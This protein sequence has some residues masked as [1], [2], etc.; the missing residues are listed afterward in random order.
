M[1]DPTPLP[2]QVSRLASPLLV[3]VLMACLAWGLADVAQRLSPTWPAAYFVGAAFV[4]ALVGYYSYHAA[5]R[6][7][8]SGITLWRYYLIE[9]VVMFLLI[10]LLAYAAGGLGRF[11]ADAARWTTQP[12]TFFDFETVAIW[13]MAVFAWAEGRAT[14]RDMDAICDP[15]LYAGEKPPLER[16]IARF[17]GGAAL[18]LAATGIARA[19]LAAALHQ[20]HPR[21][22]GLMLNVLIY[23]IV[24]LA[25]MGQL[26]FIGLEAGWRAQRYTILADLR[27]R[28]IQY[29]LLLL[30]AALL[31]AF[32]LPTGY[33]VGLLDIAAYVVA[34]IA[35][36]F[37]LLFFLISL[38]TAWL[39]ALFA[40]QGTS[41][42]SPP[43][44]PPTPPPAVAAASAG[45]PQPE[46]LLI[47]R[48]VIFWALV[49]WG[50]VQLTRYFLHDHPDL[51]PA[52]RDFNAMDGWR[53]FWR[54]LR[55]WWRALWGGIREQAGQVA[56]QVRRR[57]RPHAPSA[58]PATHRARD[59]SR[60]ARI[61]QQYLDTLAA[62]REAGWPRR[63]PQT[64][65]EYRATL[66]PALPEAADALE[67][68]TQDFIAARYSAA[69]V[70]PE[71]VQEA[72]AAAARVQAALRAANSPAEGPR[73]SGGRPAG[74]NF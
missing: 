41:E 72:Q 8:L 10:K 63:P 34:F 51:L 30:G 15:T 45:G 43:L 4:A 26:R 16:L 62:A 68:L 35:Y 22:S 1:T 47:L 27:A 21:V 7:Y 69:P 73:G 6:Q 23:F 18:L 71:Q 14:A 59:R 3:G 24:G 31:I 25:L 61:W 19:D 74:E 11:W 56:A 9:L 53:G 20:Q 38:L 12:W 37:M 42:S 44:P 46:W 55:A 54:M 32:V 48:S 52:L 49:I 2:R 58:S 70:T 65:E 60:R 33:T 5:H 28:W 39:F 29:S 13:G 67:Q 17:G 64:P 57:L 50:L 36:I 66:N 40:P